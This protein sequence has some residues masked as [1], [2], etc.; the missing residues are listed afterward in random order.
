M[1][2]NFQAKSFTVEAKDLE[3]A[4]MSFMYAIKHIRL[5]SGLPLD[6]YKNE[7]CLEHPDF[8]MKGIIDGA[9]VL[10]IDLGAEFGEQLDVRG[11][12]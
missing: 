10:G 11:C 8:A 5:A 9:R 1:T 6:K 2:Y 7:K 4:A 12:G 3:F